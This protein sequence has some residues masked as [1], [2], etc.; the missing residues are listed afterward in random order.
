MNTL[1]TRLLLWQ[2][3]G[4]GNR[5]LCESCENLTRLHGN[6]MWLFGSNEYEWHVYV[7]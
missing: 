6:Y 4:A 1:V 2:R 5:N 3:C 7:R